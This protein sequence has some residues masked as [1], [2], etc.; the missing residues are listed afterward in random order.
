MLSFVLSS[1]LLSTVLFL[2]TIYP[3]FRLLATSIY[4][5]SATKELKMATF[6]IDQEA[7][8]SATWNAITDGASS[9]I[10]ATVL[11]VLDLY[12]IPDDGQHRKLCGVTVVRDSHSLALLRFLTSSST[13]PERVQVLIASPSNVPTHSNA[14]THCLWWIFLF[15]IKI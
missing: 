15:Q 13:L 7:A 10:L 11:E 5:V 1:L 2:L 4:L 9:N 6:S 12:K 14:P 8:A 3:C